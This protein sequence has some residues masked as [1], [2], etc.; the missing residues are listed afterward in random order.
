LAA[1]L[2]FSGSAGAMSETRVSLEK[3]RQKQEPN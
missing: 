2:V 3:Q 1:L